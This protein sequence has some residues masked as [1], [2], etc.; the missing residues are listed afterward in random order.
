M[1]PL[2]L[3]LAAAVLA[4][5]GLLQGSIG[6]GSMIVAAPLLILIEP[7]LVPAPAIVAATALVVLIAWRDRAS[8]EA[9]GVGWTIIGR[10]P[11]TILGGVAVAWLS[12][13][14]LE[15]LFGALLLLAVLLSARDIHLERTPTLLFG[16]GA[17]S[18][19][20]GTATAVGG[21]PLALVYQRESGPIIRGTLNGIFVVGSL[22]S[23][24]TLAAVGELGIDELNTGL[25][26]SPGIV[27]GF[28]L[29]RRLATALD[30]RSLRPAILTFAGVAAVAVLVRAAW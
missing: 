30:A 6:F 4:V 20:M 9:R 27:F 19:L 11:G 25:A 2:D 28:A 12:Q 16:A 3:A 22:F 23:I 17:L 15:F 29:S 10:V 14:A 18:G 13:T 8:I 5:G 1:S 21:P 24:V 26:I 7:S